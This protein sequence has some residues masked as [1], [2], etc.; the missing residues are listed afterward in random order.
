MLSSQ[1]LAS[2]RQCSGRNA[3]TSGTAVRIAAAF[4]CIRSAA[5]RNRPAL[6][7]SAASQVSQYCRAGMR[8]AHDCAPPDLLRPLAMERMAAWTSMPASMCMDGRPWLSA[9]VCALAHASC[10]V[11]VAHW[12]SAASTNVARAP[13]SARPQARLGCRPSEETWVAE[14]Q[15]CTCMRGRRNPAAWHGTAPL[16]AR[17]WQPAVH[18]LGV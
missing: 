1:P 14:A 11:R 9:T 16:P 3:S 12:W 4:P 5:P 6:A 8:C 2:A 18:G 15:R 17:R 7:A 13:P 10:S